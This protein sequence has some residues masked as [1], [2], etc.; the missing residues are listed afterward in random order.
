M[1]P[2]DYFKIIQKA[3]QL[4]EPLAGFPLNLHSSFIGH[5]RIGVFDILGA[6]TTCTSMHFEIAL[7]ILTAKEVTQVPT[8]I[9]FNV[10]A[11]V[12]RY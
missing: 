9:K 2:Q 11:C 7:L 8:V 12:N 10:S 1:L 6:L 5:P 4:P 3:C